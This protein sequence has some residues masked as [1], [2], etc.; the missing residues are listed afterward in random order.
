MGD[1]DL[2]GLCFCELFDRLLGFGRK[3]PAELIGQLVHLGLEFGHVGFERRVM[4]LHILPLALGGKINFTLVGRLPLVRVVG[5]LED[6]AEAVVVTLRD[7]VVLMVVAP[8]AAY[9]D[10]HHGRREDL[11]F[12]GQNVHAL[13]DEAAFVGVGGVGCG[14][15]EAGRG[16]AVDLCLVRNLCLFPAVRHLIAGDLFGDELRVGL[17]GV[18]RANHVIAVPPGEGANT[19]I[20][21]ETF[22]IGVTRQIEPVLAPALAIVLRGQ[23]AINQLFVGVG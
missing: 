3:L 12:I 21:A 5:G 4:G 22:R 16:E 14:P 20:L 8:C 17:V 18:E 15:Q 19:I 6:G 1:G 7:G 23:K 13:V 10:A 9:G 11:H 2:C